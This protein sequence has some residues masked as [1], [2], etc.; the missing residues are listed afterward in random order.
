MAHNFGL[1]DRK[2]DSDQEEDKDRTQ[3]ER[4]ENY[5]RSIDQT[6]QSKYKVVYVGRHG[7]GYREYLN[8]FLVRSLAY[9]CRQRRRSEIWYQG[10][11]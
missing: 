10:L 5:V 9:E 4:F 8:H 2:Y 3:W 7:E 11:G 1:L 6:D